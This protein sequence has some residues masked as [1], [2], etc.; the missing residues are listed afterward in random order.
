MADK[1]TP[2]DLALDQ[3]EME[4]LEKLAAPEE[5]EDGLPYATHRGVLKIAG[6]EFEVFQLSNGQRVI[7][8]ESLEKFLGLFGDKG[9]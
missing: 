1:K 6:A 3:L 2:I 8:K 5:L 4:P 9:E 7:S